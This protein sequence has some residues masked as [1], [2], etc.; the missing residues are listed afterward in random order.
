MDFLQ[1]AKHT[2]DL[3][4]TGTSSYSAEFNITHTLRC[5]ELVK[6]YGKK[7]IDDGESLNL[8]ALEI[9]AYLHDI[10]RIFDDDTH[11]Q[12]SAQFIEK[13]FSD[14]PY[15]EILIDCAL[16]HG[17]NGNPQTKEGA[18]MQFVDKPSLL[19][20]PTLK[21]I[22]ESGTPVSNILDKC[23]DWY[24]KGFEKERDEAIQYL[25]SLE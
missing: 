5:V 8:E 20:I 25:H 10:G 22:F 7:A 9:G 2:L 13:E 24:T 12:K 3:F 21:I 11:P 6:K 17:R 4:H 1:K 16:N 23:N 15:K 18:I 14:Y 19:H